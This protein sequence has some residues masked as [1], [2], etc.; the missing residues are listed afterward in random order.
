MNKILIRSILLQDGK[1]GNY[2]FITFSEWNGSVDKMDVINRLKST[3]T[4]VITGNP[5]IAEFEILEHKGSGGPGMMWRIHA[6]VKR[7]TKQV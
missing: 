1:L 3:I 7:S 2:I 6:G 5:L 4:N